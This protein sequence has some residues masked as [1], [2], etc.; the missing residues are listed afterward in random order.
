MLKSCLPDLVDVRHC[1]ATLVLRPPFHCVHHTRNTPCTHHF[2]WQP[3]LQ[4]LFNIHYYP[5]ARFTLNYYSLNILQFDFQIR[6]VK[7]LETKLFTTIV[8]NPSNV[9]INYIMLKLMH[10]K[11]KF[12]ISLI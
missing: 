7:K 11:T 3:I 2:S 5:V 10:R 1:V 6:T 8:S 4:L 9:L 12:I